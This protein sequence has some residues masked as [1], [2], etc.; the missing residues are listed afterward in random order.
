M[1][2]MLSTIA[3]VL[4]SLNANAGVEIHSPWIRAT[5]PA[6]SIAGGFMKIRSTEQVTLTK[7]NSKQAG[8]VEIHETYVTDGIA[9]M[10]LVRSLNIPVGNGIELKP[11]SYHLMFIDIKQEYK[12]G[13]LIPLT[14][15]FKYPS[16][17]T[18]HINIDIPVKKGGEDADNHD[19]HHHH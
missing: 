16:K 13:M 9:R 17:K 19:H 11:G 6:Q 3:L 14:M 7:L 1:K 10:R 2:I 12:E 5:A 15:T 8:A 18:T 4:A